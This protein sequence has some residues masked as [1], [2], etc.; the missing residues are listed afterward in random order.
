M[1]DKNEVIAKA[2]EY[3]DYSIRKY[4]STLSN[5]DKEDIKQIGFE[6]VLHAYDRIDEERDSWK[7]F[8]QNHCNGAV[9]DYLKSPKNKMK[10]AEF[11]EFNMIQADELIDFG[12]FYNSAQE[13]KLKVNWDL[14]SRMASKDDRILLVA[15]FILGYTISDIAQNSQISRESINVKLKEFCEKLD[16]PFEVSN[17]WINQTIFAFGLC[18]HFNMVAKDNG[19]GWDLEPIDIFAK[20]MEFKKKAYT[21]QIELL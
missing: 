18:L 3:L 11:D 7:S 14:V 16:D 10:T 12:I 9:L 6:R 8:I 5:E 21:T 13:K 1:V 15:R 19:E 2:S 17:K 4:A 20:T